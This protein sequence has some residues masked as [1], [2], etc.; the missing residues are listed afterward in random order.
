M[1]SHER[2]LVVIVITFAASSSKRIRRL[3]YVSRAVCVYLSV[4]LSAEPRLH[5]R[6]IVSA[7]QVMRCIQLSLVIT[8]TTTTTTTTTTTIILLH[9]YMTTYYLS[10]RKEVGF[11][12]CL[13][14]C[15]FVCPLNHKSYERILLYFCKGGEWPQQLDFGGDS[16]HKRSRNYFKEFFVYYRDRQP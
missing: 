10:R 12:L 9:D 4:C 14:V 5:A 1:H 16:H 15:R 7:A 2:L 6:R 13:F 11:C 3:V 8:S